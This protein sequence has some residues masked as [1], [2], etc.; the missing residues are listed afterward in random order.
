L[1]APT[2]AACGDKETSFTLL[3]FTLQ[4]SVRCISG[5]K[6]EQGCAAVPSDKSRLIIPA[7]SFL[8]LLPPHDIS[9]PRA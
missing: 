9:D 8:R 7:P 2:A 6:E 1:T 5:A 3:R 4:F